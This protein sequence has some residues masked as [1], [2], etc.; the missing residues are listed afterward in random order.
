VTDIK[1][2]NLHKFHVLV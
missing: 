2:D 1:T